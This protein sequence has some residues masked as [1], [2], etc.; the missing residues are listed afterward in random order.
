[1]LQWKSVL[2]LAL[3]LVAFFGPGLVN[4][5]HALWESSHAKIKHAVPISVDSQV[6]TTW[7]LG[8]VRYCWASQTERDRFERILRS[9]INVWY[10][11]GLPE[12]RFTFTQISQA[13]CTRSRRD[14]LLVI[15]AESPYEFA[16]SVGKY[17]PEAGDF[18]HGP[19]MIIPNAYDEQFGWGAPGGSSRQEKFMHAIGHILGLYHEHQLPWFWESNQFEL[20]C[21]NLYGYEDALLRA[22][23]GIPLFDKE[24]GI[25]GN[26]RAAM[27]AGFKVAAQILPMT[28]EPELAHL[29]HPN[30]AATA[31]DVDWDSIMMYNSRSGVRQGLRGLGLKT[32]RHMNGRI[33]VNHQPTLKDV[34]ALIQLYD[35]A[36]DKAFERLYLD[37]RSEHYVTFQRI[38]QAGSCNRQLKK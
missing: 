16:T 37:P 9:A 34:Q 12:Q 24:R 27:E 32:T 23:R 38:K 31:Y 1:M 35:A 15:M 33:S 21:Q 7:P 26:R 6:V 5:G 29:H 3:W 28:D 17:V 8:E 19:I 10:A 30:R 36:V 22:P 13:E 11:A 4:A 2:G 20:N 18:N 25:C 14:S